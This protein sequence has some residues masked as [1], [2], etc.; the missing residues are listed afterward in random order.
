MT[1]I[2]ERTPIQFAVVITLLVL[3]GTIAY[4]QG[5]IQA[6]VPKEG[7]FL[8]T[9]VFNAWSSGFDRVMD[10]R[11]SSV[12]KLET[13][14]AALEKEVGRLAALLEGKQDVAPNR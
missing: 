14:M 4:Q 9:D 7:E 6:S 12:E 2:G 5:V 13:R 11:L 10:Q 8:R 3:V 1:P